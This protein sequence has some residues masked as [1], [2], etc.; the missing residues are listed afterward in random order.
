MDT[1]QL[2]AFCAVVER[3]SFSQAAERLGVT[4][5]AVSLQV[6]ALEK[7]LGTQLLD[8]SGRRVEPTEAGRRLYRA[9]QRMLAL[10]DQL[11]AEVGATGEG[12]LAGDLVL[13]AS[14]GPAAIAV[15]VVLCEFQRENPDVRVFLTVSD[16]HSV[17]ERVAARELELGIVGASRRHRGVR[18]EPFFSDQVILACPAGHR[19]ANRTVTLDELRE[20]TL[21]L[22]QEGAGVRQIVEDAL[23]RQGVRLRDLD[24]R[25]ELGLQESVRRA[26]EAGYG[27]TFISRT[28]VES[29]L[30]AG[31]L[32]EA[33]VEGLDATREIS[34]A[35]ATGRARTRVAD[36]FVAFASSPARLVI[37]RWGLG[38]LEPLLARARAGAPA[39]RDEHALRRA[40]A[41]GAAAFHRQSGGTRPIEVVEAAKR[42]VEDADGLVAL[43]GGS[44]IDTAKAVSAATGSRA[45]SRAHHLRGVRVDAVLRD[46]GRVAP[47]ED[48][49]R[50]RP[51][52]RDRVRAE[53][54][55][56]PASR[57]VR[58]DGAQRSRPLRGG[59]LR[60][61]VRRRDGRRGADCGRALP[62][63][64]VDGH[65]I[66][67]RASLLEGAM[68]AG[69]AL[70]ERGLFLAH[71]MAQALGG[72]VRRLRTARRTRSASHLRFASTSP[73]CRMRSSRLAEALAA[74]DVFTRIEELARLGGYERLRDLG[75]PGD[76]LAELAA[77]T[78]ERPGCAR[79]SASRHTVRRRGALPLDLVN[80]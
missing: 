44:A 41:S 6:R 40:R 36:A 26:V 19:F 48:R 15:P 77:E 7:R 14:T 58:R 16:T 21:I 79:E 61:V 49:W 23:R 30:A 71:A 66:A 59:S 76:E 63:V 33:R 10:E 22:M 5:P 57:R 18:F 70:A 62:D 75:V 13:G 11:V 27:V 52:G 43:G 47:R 78:A 45:R 39:A 9:A 56:R 65:D 25:L 67:A 42:A 3:R 51:D 20:E 50:R 68:H 37:V 53:P 28:A 34:L 12:A 54:D 17:I 60:G 55:A 24:V 4:Q 38:E 8:R 35:S 1:R 73:S 72:P 32:A 46:A 29:D 2:A 64:V 31:R 80:G 69:R 74:P